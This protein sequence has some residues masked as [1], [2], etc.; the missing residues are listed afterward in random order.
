[1]TDAL[2]RGQAANTVRG[3]APRVKDTMSTAAT[4]A[5]VTPAGTAVA[6]PT[7][8]A[9]AAADNL[10]AVSVEAVMLGGVDLNTDELKK[11]LRATAD[12]RVQGELNEAASKTSLNVTTRHGA[13]LLTVVECFASKVRVTEFNDDK[14][15][16]RDDFIVTIMRLHEVKEQLTALHT[17]VT[18]RQEARAAKAAAKAAARAAARAAEAAAVKARVK[19]VVDAVVQVTGQTVADVVAKAITEAVAEV[20]VMT[21][22]VTVKAVATKKATMAKGVAQLPLL[23]PTELTAVWNRAALHLW[24]ARAARTFWTAFASMAVWMPQQVLQVLDR[25]QN[26]E[27]PVS[28]ATRQEVIVG[29]DGVMARS[30]WWN[31]PASL[32]TRS[33][34]WASL[35]KTATTRAL[36]AANHVAAIDDCMVTCLERK[37]GGKATGSPIDQLVNKQVV[38]GAAESKG[39]DGEEA[40]ALDA[41]ALVRDIRG[42]FARRFRVSTR[43]ARK[44]GKHDVRHN[45]QSN[46]EWWTKPDSSK[47]Q[48][49]R[50]VSYA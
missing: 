34:G 7:T 24:R 10:D 21:E 28:Q 6:A 4:T 17:T 27:A 36:Y 30:A 22:V 48:Q 46:R 14:A 15:M 39:G 40:E 33:P 41:L 37:G 49:Y 20:V 29:V 13:P 31:S 5:V 8:G 45:V 16:A 2:P 25:M 38:A 3:W 44:H 50:L 23:T 12:A 9:A 26:K 18:R 42:K 43:Q 1:M 19:A 35:T 11:E 32:Q 47:M